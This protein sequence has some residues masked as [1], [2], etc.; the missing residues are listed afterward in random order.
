MSK[1]LNVNT[2]FLKSN[3]LFYLNRNL[4]K[5]DFLKFIKEAKVHKYIDLNNSSLNILFRIYSIG[6]LN[7]LDPNSNFNKKFKNN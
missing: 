3:T 1:K 2:D 6:I 4:I 7:T 5:A